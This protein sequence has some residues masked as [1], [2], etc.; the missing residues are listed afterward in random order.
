MPA[1]FQ[2][3]E[4]KPSDLPLNETA[5]DRLQPPGFPLEAEN[6]MQ[7]ED[8]LGKWESASLASPPLQ[9]SLTRWVFDPKICAVR[10]EPT[11]HLRAA[12]ISRGVIRFR[13]NDSLVYQ[14]DE[15]WTFAGPPDRPGGEPEYERRSLAHGEYPEKEKWIFAGSLTCE[16]DSRR[17]YKLTTTP[18][19]FAQSGLI[20]FP[21][22]FFNIQAAVLMERFWIRDVTPPDVA[23]QVWLEFWPK[24]R[25]L[26]FNCGKTIVRLS[27][28]SLRAVV[29]EAYRENSEDPEGLTRFAVTEISGPE[30]IEAGSDED[31]LNGEPVVPPGWKI[32]ERK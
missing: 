29:V 1:L 28:E 9:C 23:D 5:P 27:R 10:N 16:Y 21:R 8:L 3:P 32:I 2:Q 22:P 11:N 25:A 20:D 13:G 6:Q 14:V 24:R 17:L 19:T 15:K 4:K 12:E 26:F 18:E 30:S 7:I 31:F